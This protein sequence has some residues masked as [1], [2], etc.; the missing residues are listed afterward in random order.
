MARPASLNAPKT[1][2]LRD[3]SDPMLGLYRISAELNISD[4]YLSTTFKTAFGIGVVQ[5]INS[6]RIEQAKKN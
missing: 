6:L 3:F 2:I 4:S 5:Y 1:I